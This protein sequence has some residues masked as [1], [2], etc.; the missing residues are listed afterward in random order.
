MELSE[1][2]KILSIGKLENS[3]IFHQNKGLTLIKH[4]VEES[5]RP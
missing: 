5:P 2:M 3:E 1:R 4:S